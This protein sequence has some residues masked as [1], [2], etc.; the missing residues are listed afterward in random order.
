MDD[1]Y[2]FYLSS[3]LWEVVRETREITLCTEEVVPGFQRVHIHSLASYLSVCL[4]FEGF[5]I[6]YQVGSLHCSLLLGQDI[7][8]DFLLASPPLWTVPLISIISVLK[9]AEE[10]SNH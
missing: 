9:L 6:I 5:S 7:C 8:T 1:C 10:V 4:L 3:G 2:F